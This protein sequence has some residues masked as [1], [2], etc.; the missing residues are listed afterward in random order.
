MS[1]KAR[2]FEDRQAEEVDENGNV[3]MEDGVSD[4]DPEDAEARALEEL[5]LVD[6]APIPEDEIDVYNQAGEDLPGGDADMGGLDDD[7][8]D[9]N[10][11][12]PVL[13]RLKKA[14]DLSAAGD[15]G[16]SRAVSSRSTPRGAVAS[17]GPKTRNFPGG[18]LLPAEGEEEELFG[19]M[20]NF[21]VNA[22]SYAA[23]GPSGAGVGVPKM[24][25]EFEEMKDFIAY[26][27]EEMEQMQQRQRGMDRARMSQQE[28]ISS[29]TT[30][31]QADLLAAFGPHADIAELVN[32][33]LSFLKDVD[34]QR[35]LDKMQPEERADFDKQ[36]AHLVPDSVQRELE[37]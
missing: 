16:S 18:R 37:S 3:V 11:G 21:G 25:G 32:P 26:T 14:G 22:S 6:D 5:G 30:E 15:L 27:A 33:N 12:A 13:S 4:E 29:L 7:E 23:A 31:E 1:S 24:S 2:N 17:P 10:A 20:S 35:R 8:D 19:D 9:D 36:K 34:Q 28:A